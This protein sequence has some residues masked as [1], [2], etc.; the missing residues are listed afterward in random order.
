MFS[1]TTAANKS[2]AILSATIASAITLLVCF[3]MFRWG[4]ILLWQ[5]R[6]GGRRM[7]FV[8]DPEINAAVVAVLLSIA[9]FFIIRRRS[10]RQ[11]KS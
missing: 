4:F 3:W 7:V 11:G 1:M 6:H 10:S 9:I 2:A 5:W 8:I